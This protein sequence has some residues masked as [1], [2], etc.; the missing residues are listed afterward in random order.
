MLM[1]TFVN[2]IRLRTNN[3]NCLLIAVKSKFVYLI[4][5]ILTKINIQTRVRSNWNNYFEDKF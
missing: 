2:F 5:L 3:R 1:L 4:T